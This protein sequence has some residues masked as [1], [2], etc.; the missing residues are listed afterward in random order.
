MI[1]EIIIIGILVLFIIGV[2]YQISVVNREYKDAVDAEIA[3][4]QK[5]ID[6]IE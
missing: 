4:L 2:C 5:A 6:E 3:R 1:T